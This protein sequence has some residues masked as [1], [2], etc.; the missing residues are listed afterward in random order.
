MKG[1]QR[2][3]DTY[4]TW[5]LQIQYENISRHVV[6]SNVQVVGGVDCWNAQLEMQLVIHRQFQ[7]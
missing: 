4:K 5:G 1:P 6:R 3:H 2:G 7:L